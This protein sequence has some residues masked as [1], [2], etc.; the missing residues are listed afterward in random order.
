M[1][2]NV[3]EVSP[4]SLSSPKS[5]SGVRKPA[6]KAAKQVAKAMKSKQPSKKK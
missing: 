3:W 5:K 2:L 1:Q 6:M 4:S